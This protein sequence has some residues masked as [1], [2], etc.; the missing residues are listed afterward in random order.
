MNFEP[1]DTDLFLID[2]ERGWHY[3]VRGC[4]ATTRSHVAA[5]YVELP[6]SDIKRRTTHSGTRFEP[7]ICV[8]GAYPIRGK[9]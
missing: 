1:K 6:Y 7:D 9:S 5:M 4:P 2:T 3:H 8:R